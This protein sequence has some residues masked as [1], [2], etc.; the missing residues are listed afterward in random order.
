[1]TLAR[2][3]W[4]PLAWDEDA[5][6]PTLHIDDAARAITAS[7]L[8]PGGTYNVADTGPLTIRQL[9]AEL[10]AIAGRSR[11]HPLHERVRPADRELL[12]RSC[13]LDSRAFA[14]QTGW[15][16]TT[17]PTAAYGLRDLFSARD[18]RGYRGWVVS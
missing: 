1:M 6:F 7:M 4:Q 3:G 14:R 18:G 9:H 10:A 2:R 5:Y 11:L 16:P 12:T 17:A 15:E 13:N 8:I